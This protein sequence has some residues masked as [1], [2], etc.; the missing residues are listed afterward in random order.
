MTPNKVCPVVVRESAHGLE[1][2]MFRHPRGG[3]QLVK[4]TI[5]PGEAPQ[6]A[7]RREL[8]EESGIAEARIVEDLGLWDADQAQQIWSFQ[9]CEPVQPL[10]DAWSHHCADGDGHL[11]ELFWHPLT[12]E[13]TGA[14]PVFVRA[15]RCIR[16]RLRGVP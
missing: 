3:V 6:A 4:G 2:L 14:H 15:V 13:P 11:F 16:E 5:E 7:A 10:P 12:E 9:R 1:I 8:F